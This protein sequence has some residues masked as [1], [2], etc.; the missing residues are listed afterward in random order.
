[1]FPRLVPS[2]CTSRVSAVRITR[3]ASGAPYGWSRDL[4]MRNALTPRRNQRRQA[5]PAAHFLDASDP[6]GFFQAACECGAALPYEVV[7]AD[8]ICIIDPITRRDEINILK[9][10]SL[11]LCE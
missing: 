11:F 4:G 3:K 10:G 7:A 6:I 5:L 8:R 2:L 1:M 9:V